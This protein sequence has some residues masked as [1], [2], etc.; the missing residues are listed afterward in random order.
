MLFGETPSRII[1]SAKPEHVDRIKEIAAQNGIICSV[2]GKVGGNRLTI[3]CDGEKLVDTPIAPLESSW[4]SALS[5]YLDRPA[6][7]AAD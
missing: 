3:S 1:L 4:R 6:Q 2:I 7:M 5:T